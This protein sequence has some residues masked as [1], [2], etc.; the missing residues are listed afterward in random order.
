MVVEDAEAVG[1]K[2]RLS[3]VR[4]VDAA[5]GVDDDQDLDPMKSAFLGDLAT[6]DEA[7]VYDVLHRRYA[8]DAIYTYGALESLVV[9][10]PFRPVA[11]LQD[12]SK[13][14]CMRAPLTAEERSGYG[15]HLSGREP[16][17][18]SMCRSAWAYQVRTQESVS[19][20]IQG[21][22]GAGKTETAKHI[23]LFFSSLPKGGSPQHRTRRSG[24]MSAPFLEHRV[25]NDAGAQ[26]V[27]IASSP[28][29]E[30]LGNARTLRN[31]NSSRFGRFVRLFIDEQDGTVRAADF[32]AYF[33][34][35]S[36]VT[37]RCAGERS[38][39]VFYQLLAGVSEE[40]RARHKLR[41]TPAEY[42]M[43]GDASSAAEVLR[44]VRQ[45]SDDPSDHE[46]WGEEVLP[47]LQV[48][49][50]QGELLE[51]VL[52]L[53]SAVLLCGEAR[54]DGGD[55]ESAASSSPDI[56]GQI[57]ELLG[58][59]V[60]SLEESLT[61]R[62][63]ML[64]RGTMV[65][66]PL[67]PAQAT[68]LTHAVARCLYEGLFKWVIEL[69]NRA[70][71]GASA[72]LAGPVPGARSG[73]LWMGVLDIFGFEAFA[74][75]SLEQLL[76]NYCNE[77]VH[78][79]FITA[80]HKSELEALRAD[81]ASMESRIDFDDNLQIIEAIDCQQRGRDPGI[82]MLLEEQCNLQ[83]G[84]DENFTMACHKRFRQSPA[85]CYVEPRIAAN[86]SF[87]INHSCCSITYCTDQ[88][89]EKNMDV[90]PEDVRRLLLTSNR[91]LIRRI[92]DCADSDSSAMV[93]TRSTGGR[94]ENI[95]G[96]FLKSIS[97]LLTVLGSSSPRFVKQVK[98]NA[99]KEPMS[100][101]ESFVRN[102]LNTL[103]IIESIHVERQGFT[104][105]K[106]FQVFLKD[107][108]V[109]SQ[110]KMGLAGTAP[111]QPRVQAEMLLQAVVAG[112]D[113][114]AKL[115]P[116]CG[117]AP[118]TDALL[119]NLG[120]SKVFLTHAMH[121][122]CEALQAEVE[123]NWE[124]LALQLQSCLRARAE[125][126]CMRKLDA[127]AAH[128][129]RKFRR[130]RAERMLWR[131]RKRRRRTRGVWRCSA[132]LFLFYRR[133]LQQ[134]HAAIQIQRHSRGCRERASYQSR[135]QTW[136]A[137]LALRCI[138]GAHKSYAA[139]CLLLIMEAEDECEAALLIQSKARSILARAFLLDEKARHDRQSAALALQTKIH[140][141]RAQSHLLHLRRR[142]DVRKAALVLRVK[143]RAWFAR[144]QLHQ[145]RLVEQQRA[146]AIVLKSQAR[147]WTASLQI[148][149]ARRMK[150]VAT[151]QRCLRGLRARK[152]FLDAMHARRAAA[153]RE[154]KVCLEVMRCRLKFA[155]QKRCEG[156]LL[157]GKAFS[158]SRS[159]NHLMGFAGRHLQVRRQPTPSRTAS[160]R[161]RDE[162]IVPSAPDLHTPVVT[163]FA[164]A[165][166]RDVS[167]TTRAPSGRQHAPSTAGGLPLHGDGH[168][169][170]VRERGASP[171]GSAAPSPSLSSFAGAAAVTA[172]ATVPPY[173]DAMSPKAT[174]GG[175]S[176]S[177]AFAT[178]PR[179]ASPPGT[180][181]RQRP[182]GTHAT[183]RPSSR[184]R[185]PGY[186]QFAPSDIVESAPSQLKQWTHL[187]RQEV[188]ELYT[189]G[190]LRMSP[191]RGQQFPGTPGPGPLLATSGGVG[192]GAAV[193]MGASASSRRSV[194]A[195][196]FV[197][198]RQFDCNPQDGV[199]CTTT[200]E[201]GL[202]QPGGD[203]AGGTARERT[204]S[205]TVE[206]RREA[207]D[208]RDDPGM[209]RPVNGFDRPAVPRL[210]LK[211]TM[212]DDR[213]CE[214]SEAMEAPLSQPLPRQV[215]SPGPSSRF[216]RGQ[217]PHAGGLRQATPR[218]SAA[219]AGG[220]V[221]TP[222]RKTASSSGSATQRA[223]AQR[224][225]AGTGSIPCSRPS[226]ARG[227]SGQAMPGT[228]PPQ[229]IPQ[230]WRPVGERR[231]AAARTS[232]PSS[233]STMPAAR[234]KGRPTN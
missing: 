160:R 115:S 76:I 25:V 45:Q 226:S 132:L 36:R 88:F 78:Q 181:S 89:R 94:Q 117:A 72:H 103:G 100:M 207:Q 13:L 170:P 43:L 6:V 108:A 152:A 189:S 175:C 49:G 48:L 114:F 68:D 21:E 53:L 150:A 140:S 168:Q 51:E 58:F 123:A 50:V 119:F 64:P 35:K 112:G 219:A 46:E 101:E 183:P 182:G 95:A 104:Y 196:P 137:M 11:C 143:A 141:R 142:Q 133:V 128:L 80:V 8:G 10:N 37:L 156:Y 178:F 65:T 180:P 87:E 31:D 84:S 91:D 129:Q 167:S 233:G 193:E 3:S 5:D 122:H 147:K 55:E 113:S 118:K 223:V 111:K 22:S 173:L 106:D 174:G 131:K 39:H 222:R 28:L 17:I 163:G 184:Q 208:E 153:A 59:D 14:V 69:I 1:W 52:A 136:R 82:I 197:S 211:D 79:F 109:L 190:A 231:V 44:Q 66:S 230:P 105:R 47:A 157:A 162:G 146:A 85:K 15:P 71:L 102:Q 77:R 9:C 213:G 61:T 164:A 144:K 24:R 4:S 149:Y 81:G 18:W 158:V 135:V 202:V 234:P 70:A 110:A 205:H 195:A 201:V 38:F 206:V 203:E 67:K 75:N 209:L 120:R 126:R 23:M 159:L 214:M 179:Y 32:S 83:T 92:F 139:R 96:Q 20:V 56:L 16:H 54:W 188:H 60:H 210:W 198:P 116:G 63:R 26:S 161:V 33:L 62:R 172:A 41:R 121:Q 99:A 199:A 232:A 191:R 151:F 165:E 97:A 217:P 98:S 90:M 194:D 216:S 176:V 187:A 27:I 148:L 19:F 134:R 229:S 169:C 204:P 57:A 192:A 200:D 218:A 212:D 107:F 12:Q 127:A 145:A 171:A 74:K 42:Q 73:N 220:L 7:S 30:A 224:A 215:Q 155:E 166:S 40:Q 29:Q 225:K 138:R 124:A 177:P 228:K 86:R 93:A 130:C 34:E 227:P 221:D 185:T 186:S 154:L 2:L 125:S